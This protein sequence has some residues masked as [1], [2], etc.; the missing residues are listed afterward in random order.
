MPPPP[1]PKRIKR[2][3]TVLDED[4]YTQAL[5]HIIAR[6]YFPGL[7]ETEAQE[8][9]MD[10]LEAKDKG[11]IEDAGKRMREAMTPR[12]DGQKG[13]RGVNM[14][15][16]TGK[17]GA[18][19][20]PRGW[21]GD[22]PA[23]VASTD[24][25]Q[26]E[27]KNQKPKVDLNLSLTAFQAK[28]TSEDNES[29]NTSL[30]KQNA[31]R[32]EKYSW[33]YNGNQIPTARQIAWRKRDVKLLEAADREHTNHDRD[34]DNV[35]SS[36]SP[37]ADAES[38]STIVTRTLPS[39][40]S[41]RPAMPL[42]RPSAPR[43][44]FMF[45]PSSIES[46]YQTR[47][48]A[49]AAA[50][51][52]PPKSVSYT[53]TRFAAPTS[54]TGDDNDTASNPHAIPPSPSLSAINDAI[55]GQP[56]DATDSEAGY[57][58]AETPRVNGYTFVDA[59]PTEA[60]RRMAAGEG[61]GVDERLEDKEEED[62]NQSGLQLLRQLRGGEAAQ[63][64]NPFT[65]HAASKREDLLHRMV[66]RQNAQ[67]RVP[68]AGVPRLA[69]LMGGKMPG[70]GTPSATPRFASAAGIKSRGAG[71]GGLTPAG[72]RLLR[73]VGTPKR[74]GL[75]GGERKKGEASKA[76]TPTARMRRKVAE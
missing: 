25:Q 24:P 67:K 72:E 16:V 7:L 47:A 55:R 20:T 33:I 71:Q 58:G 48:E 22:T 75:F 46:E 13:R 14:T 62:A 53:S 30:D 49:A 11:W 6:D 44:T 35:D 60:E 70:G 76:W 57:N 40:P 56:R 31:K 65:I 32:A 26:E 18:S 5:S 42:H 73:S 59:E 38:A 9:F 66:D 15:P 50:S 17:I 23:S 63:G 27:E 21:A 51:N 10:A 61:G 36:K 54:L 39:K 3:S 74:E 64:P 19:Q 37:S 2:P 34:N 43:N 68:G 4:D 69:E 45:Q 41:S 28:Y 52:A 29:F 1:P 8:E 12:R